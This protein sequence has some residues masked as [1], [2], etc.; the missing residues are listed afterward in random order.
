M[1]SSG[2]LNIPLHSQY[3]DESPASFTNSDVHKENL[4]IKTAKEM[5][6]LSKMVRKENTNVQ[7]CKQHIVTP[8]TPGDAPCCLEG[9]RDGAQ[10]QESKQE[11]RPRWWLQFK[12]SQPNFHHTSLYTYSLDIVISRACAFSYIAS[13]LIFVSKLTLRRLMSYIY[14]WS[15]HSWCF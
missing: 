3:E 12:I 15:T 1:S 6:T 11:G 4:K 10:P 2:S 13:I 9:D 14:I 5:F 8:E 7:T